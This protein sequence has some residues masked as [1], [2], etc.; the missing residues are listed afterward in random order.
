MR[1]YEWKLSLICYW[2]GFDIEYNFPY[3]REYKTDFIQWDF[4]LI[5]KWVWFWT[6]PKLIIDWWEHELI[7]KDEEGEYLKFKISWEIKSREFYIQWDNLMKSNKKKLDFKIP[8]LKTVSI[9]SDK[10]IICWDDLNWGKSF[11]FYLND[12]EF[13]NYYIKDWCFNINDD[14]LY[15]RNDIYIENNWIKSNSIT[16]N[17]EVIS[18]IIKNISLYNTWFVINW[19]NFW[20]IKDYIDVYQ[21]LN[22]LNINYFSDEKIIIEW[23]INKK[24]S[25]FYID[26]SWV[27]SNYYLFKEG[28]KKSF[29]RTKIKIF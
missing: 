5:V 26:K 21:D 22:K 20:S 7:H 1:S 27:K 13:N 11:K 6:D 10:I 2:R 16:F 28:L 25:Y 17:Y 14:Y 18:P 12:I 29:V 9:K 15:Y 3:I 4:Y 24:N 23:D 19:K 8:I